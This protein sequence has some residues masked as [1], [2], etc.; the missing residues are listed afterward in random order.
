MPSSAPEC[1]Q[2]WHLCLSQAGLGAKDLLGLYGSDCTPYSQGA[3]TNDLPRGTTLNLQPNIPLPHPYWLG[4]RVGEVVFFFFLSCQNGAVLIYFLF[5]NDQT[6]SYLFPFSCS[7]IPHYWICR[8]PAPV[9]Q[10]YVR[11]WNSDKK[12]WQQWENTPFQIFSSEVLGISP[13]SGLWNG[14]SCQMT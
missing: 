13:W 12:T 9:C 14:C 3:G 6:L 2:V 7:P 11:A 10:A 8:I 4:L 1:S 5:R